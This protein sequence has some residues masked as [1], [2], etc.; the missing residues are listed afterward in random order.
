[1]RKFRKAMSWFLV[2]G[3]LAAMLAG[4]KS[5]KATSRETGGAKESS[6]TFPLATPATLK[7]WQPAISSLLGQ[8]P[9]QSQLPKYKELEKRLN[10]KVQLITPALG[11]ERDQFNLMISSG[12]LPDILDDYSV[13][14]YYSG[15]IE[16]AY[17]DGLII[18][19]NDLQKKY[20]PDLEKIYS[21]YGDIKALC[22]DDNG[23]YLFVPFIRGE[24][25]MSSFA[26]LTVRQ[27]WLNK[28]GLPVPQTIDDWTNML[29]QFKTKMGASSP[30]LMS[31]ASTGSSGS[32]D[33]GTLSGT[34]LIGTYG[35][36]YTYFI[37]SGKV[38]YGP[39][40][41]RYKDFLKLMA[42]WYKS[43]LIDPELATNSQ[44]TFQAKA[45]SNK[46]GAFYCNTGSG[47][48][49]FTQQMAKVDPS[50]K[51]AGVPYP[52]LK[53]GDTNRFYQTANPVTPQA[54]I[55][56]KCEHPDIAMAYLN[57]G[58]TKEGYILYNFGI[59]GTSFNWDNGSPKYADLVT[60]NPNG[61]AMQAA[62]HMYTWAVKAGNMVQDPR[63]QTQYQPYQEQQDAVKTWSA[64]SSKTTPGTNYI[65]Q[66][67]LT[68]DETNSIASA[69]T[70]INTY[71][72]EMFLKFV[73]GIQPITDANFN[74]YVSQLKALGLDNTLK[75]RQ[76][77]EDRFKKKNPEF[78]ATKSFSNP[79]D[80]YKDIRK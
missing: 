7:V 3:V 8:Y 22:R 42:Q 32:Y 38:K 10:V 68:A 76:T 21:T 70:Q 62:L 75:V 18:K 6:I 52:V 80:L 55:S 16:K 50:Y 71:R 74:S 4:C 28:L 72:D 54:C 44:K 67:R 23:D 34:A 73:E 78:Y 39:A 59:E 29:T 49:T 17:S 51:L 41:P 65:P 25:W 57:Y 77:A 33:N 1:M 15:G 43:G 46:S 79:Y 5:E 37:E 60:K 12:S 63:Y 14:N 48:G 19:L 69:E 2:V 53:K 20:A 9:D 66:G 58:F 64:A 30:F 26:G 27:D 36:D 47:I 40:D 13:Q 24:S 35:I 56:S 11:Q 31:F 45:M 61:L